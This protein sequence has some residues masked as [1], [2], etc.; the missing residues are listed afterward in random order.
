MAAGKP[1]V[2]TQAEGVLELLGAGAARQSC[3]AGDAAGFAERIVR[4]ANDASLA[5]ELGAQNQRRAAEFS[6]QGMISRYEA[7]YVS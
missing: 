2:A 7:L 6:L 3:P 5:A 1:V 4:A